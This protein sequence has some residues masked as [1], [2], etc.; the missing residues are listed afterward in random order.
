MEYL[1]G[2]SCQ[3]LFCLP[4]LGVLSM[5]RY[6][7]P[8]S[9][10]SSFSILLGN[11]PHLDMQYTIFAWVIAAYVASWS[12]PLALPSL[13]SHQSLIWSFS[14]KASA[15]YALLLIPM[16]LSRRVTRG[17]DVVHKLEELPTKREGIFVMPLERITI[18]NTYW[19]RVNGPFNLTLEGVF[20]SPIQ[21]S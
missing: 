19:Y 12:R 6:N 8:N 16:M 15:P 14:L 17:M 5:G 9:G 18:L 11:A 7:D 21:S 2:S 4:I 10:T 1:G 3:L 13:T 20:F